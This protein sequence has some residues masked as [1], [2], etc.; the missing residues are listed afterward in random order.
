[1]LAEITCPTLVL[2]TGDNR[3]VTEED[4]FVLHE[5]LPGS[6]LLRARGDT[7]YDLGAGTTG[8][9][10]EFVVGDVDSYVAARELA[11]LVMY[12]IVG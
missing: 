8:A 4:S 11:V 9:Y 3:H 2:Y 6:Q 12:D 7:Y 10:I 1:M 5:H